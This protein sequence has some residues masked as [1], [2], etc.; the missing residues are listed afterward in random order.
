MPPVGPRKGRHKNCGLSRCPRGGAP[1]AWYHRDTL[2]SC[3]PIGEIHFLNQQVSSGTLG[4]PLGVAELSLFPNSKP[5][6]VLGGREVHALP[7]FPQLFRVIRLLLSLEREKTVW[8][9]WG[10]YTEVRAL[11]FVTSPAQ[12]PVDEEF[13]RERFHSFI[14]TNQPLVSGNEQEKNVLPEKRTMENIPPKTGPVQHTPCS[15]PG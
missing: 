10:A 4:R 14:L 13:Q 1:H 6:V 11:T 2:S 8:E 5:S 7:G 15:V 12:I 3:H 9:A